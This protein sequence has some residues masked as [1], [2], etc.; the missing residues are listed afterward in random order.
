MSC[1][2]MSL[3][4]SENSQ[5]NTCAGVPLLIKLQVSCNILEKET[6]AKVFLCEFCETFK[7]NLST[8]H[9]CATAP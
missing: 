4:I 7:G 3:K 8:E 1:K 5:E 9:L 6:Q 2:K